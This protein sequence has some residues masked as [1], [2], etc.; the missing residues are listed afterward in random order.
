MSK[1]SIFRVRFLCALALLGLMSTS[2]MADTVFTGVQ[3][4]ARSGTTGSSPGFTV[5]PANNS[6]FWGGE[7]TV[8]TI[9]FSTGYGAMGE[10]N[11][12]GFLNPILK[13]KA[14]GFGLE[15]VTSTVGMM[16]TYQ[17]NGTTS[18][19]VNYNW[20]LDAVLTEMDP[21]SAAFLRYRAGLI[22]GAD[23]FTTSYVDF[24][25]SSA[26]VVDSINFT[27]DVAGTIDESG[28]LSIDVDPGEVFYL[29]TLLLTYGGRAG[30]EADAFNTSVG[31]FSVTGGGTIVSLS[32]VP[33][34][35]A[36]SLIALVG[37][38][39]LVIRRRIN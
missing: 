38:A 7:G 32:A 6:D 34:P 5:G 31:S 25:E 1:K 20:A 17:Y 10:A 22:S 16:A 12:N 30:G 24:F 28:T 3:A 15:G 8:S 37:L 14:T 29:S 26:D 18:G 27:S 11:P 13:S 2:L 39:G 36:G 4:S 33:E 23:F 35:A 9:A 19:T 21:D